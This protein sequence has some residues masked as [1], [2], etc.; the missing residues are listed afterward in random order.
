M[1]LLSSQ[2]AHQ[3]HRPNG[4]E[5]V[6]NEAA[7][8]SGGWGRS[9]TQVPV[10]CAYDSTDVRLRTGKLR[11]DCG[12]PLVAPSHP[13]V[14]LTTRFPCHDHSDVHDDCTPHTVVVR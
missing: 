12:L 11:S 5:G 9:E 10:R 7:R 6:L 1:V 8:T 13:A 3:I 14:E 2:Y 4:P